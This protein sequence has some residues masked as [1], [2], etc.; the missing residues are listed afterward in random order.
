MTRTYNRNMKAKSEVKS[1]RPWRKSPLI[2]FKI[3]VTVRGQ[4]WVT[5]RQSLAGLKW[6]SPGHVDIAPSKRTILGWYENLGLWTPKIRFDQSSKCMFLS[7]LK[8]SDR[9]DPRSRLIEWQTNE[10][11]KSKSEVK[12]QSPWRK[13]QCIFLKIDVTVRPQKWVTKRRSLAGLE[14]ESPK[15]DRYCSFKQ[16]HFGRR[17]NYWFLGCKSDVLIKTVEAQE[18]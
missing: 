16:K 6:E 8:P 2:F 9:L 15:L 13:S 1:Q 7:R 5:K 14:W 12:I 17:R 3:D 4:K 18:R 10:E 11:M